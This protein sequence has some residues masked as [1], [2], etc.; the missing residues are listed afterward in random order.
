VERDRISELLRQLPAQQE[1]VI[2]L[3]FGLGCRR[4][5]S[6]DEMAQE[7][8]VSRRVVTGILEAAERK[9]AGEGVTANELRQGAGPQVPAKDWQRSTEGGRRQCR[10]RTLEPRSG[11]ANAPEGA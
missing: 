5:H 7:F 6:I 1:K 9:L 11:R 10:S 3:Y 2:R 8:G 4:P